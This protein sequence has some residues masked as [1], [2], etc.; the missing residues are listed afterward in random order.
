MDE[1]CTRAQKYVKIFDDVEDVL[2]SEPKDLEGRTRMGELVAY[3]TRFFFMAEGFLP[4]FDDF[5]KVWQIS[6][7][8]FRF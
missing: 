8:L 7:Q 5:C 6:P 4:S 1:D 2:R 3:K